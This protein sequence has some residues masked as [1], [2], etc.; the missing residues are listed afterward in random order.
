MI[1]V[2]YAVSHSYNSAFIM[3]T[4]T[5]SSSVASLIYIPLLTSVTPARTN[6]YITYD[7]LSIVCAGCAP[8]VRPAHIDF[9][10]QKRQFEGMCAGVRQKTGVTFT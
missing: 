8:D 7:Q 4:L 9:M 2:D 5:F 3:T 6:S 10:P 1:L